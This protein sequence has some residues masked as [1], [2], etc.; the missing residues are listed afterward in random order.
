MR[1][2]GAVGP[3]AREELDPASNHMSE[4]GSVSHPGES[5]AEIAAPVSAASNLMGEP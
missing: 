4:C 2:Q 3:A 5:S 1:W